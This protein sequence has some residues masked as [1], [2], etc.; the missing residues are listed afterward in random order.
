MIKIT[1]EELIEKI[2]G[3]KGNTFVSLDIKSEPRMRKTDNPYMGAE[4]IVRLSGAINF[5]YGNSVNSQL[6]RE[7][8]EAD[9]KPK[10]RKW[11][12]REGN[13]ITHKG[14]HYLNVKVQDSSE[15]IYLY[16]D[17]KIEKAKLEPWLQKSSKPK[18]Q[19][20]LETEV[21]VRDVKI[22]SIKIIRMKGEE[23]VVV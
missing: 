1:K 20:D 2:N 8:K 3:I 12:V 6:V 22:D 11:G 23:F 7:G 15:P 5:D 21:V 16:N 18:T 19:E 14:N 10:P 9:F 13:W 17:V 4:K